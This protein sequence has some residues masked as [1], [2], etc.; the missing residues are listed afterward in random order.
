[1]DKRTAFAVLLLVGAPLQ[2]QI[3]RGT[4][5]L[6]TAPIVQDLLEIRVTPGNGQTPGVQYRPDPKDDKGFKTLIEGQTFVAPGEIDLAFP[7]FSPLRYA[8]TTSETL[9]A[10]ENFNGVQKFLEALLGLGRV[11]FPNRADLAEAVRAADTLM[12]AAEAAPPRTSNC[13]EYELLRRTLLRLQ[14]Q[15]EVELVGQRDLQSWI[16]GSTGLDNVRDTRIKIQEKSTKVSESLDELDELEKKIAAIARLE[17][18]G[19]CAEIRASTFAQVYELTRDVPRTRQSLNALKKSLDGLNKALEPFT[20]PTSWRGDRRTT[21]VFHKASPS[22]QNGKELKIAIHRTGLALGGEG[23]IVVKTEAEVTRTITL[24]Q[25]SR[26]VPEFSAAM[27]YSDVEYPKWGTEEKD[28]MMVVAP[29]KDD[30]ANIEGAVMLNLIL[31]KRTPSFVYPAFQLGISSA[32]DVP[33]LLAGVGLR[34]T[35]PTTWSLM[36]GGMLTWA[37]DLNN[38]KPGDVVT[39]TAQIESD[40]TLKRQD[41]ALY[42]AFQYNF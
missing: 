2:A 35:Q 28:G 41:P 5:Q 15:T 3:S 39:G 11:A 37:K 13:N 8:V 42:V 26:L 32:E 36:V 18:E 1:M 9:V 25:Y 30:T 23:G 10:D 31:R 29:V 4:N 7:D 33:G 14:T 27:I 24:R 12:A 16:E 21:W 34:F 17:D 22:F 6:L 20:E 19:F 38:L 40:L